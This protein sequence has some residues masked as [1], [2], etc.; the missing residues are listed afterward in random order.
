[1]DKVFSRMQK[2]STLKFVPRLKDDIKSRYST[3]AT[4]NDFMLHYFG[5]K[6]NPNIGLNYSIGKKRLTINKDGIRYVIQN[7]NN[8]GLSDFDKIINNLSKEKPDLVLLSLPYRGR[9]LISVEEEADQ[10]LVKYLRFQ[11]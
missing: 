8:H 4:K 6:S 7:I 5:I 3:I 1:M 11:S 10:E 9:S 2:L